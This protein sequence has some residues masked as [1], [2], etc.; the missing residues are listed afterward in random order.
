MFLLKCI[1]IHIL[2]NVFLLIQMLEKYEN[3]KNVKVFFK[4]KK[5]CSI[6]EAKCQYTRRLF[7]SVY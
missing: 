6:Y 3:V 5:R 2:F 7:L 4:R 1:N